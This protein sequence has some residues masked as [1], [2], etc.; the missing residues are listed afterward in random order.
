[1]TRRWGKS[2]LYTLIAVAGIAWLW[3]QMASVQS[4]IRLN[5]VRYH[6]SIMRT[7]AERERGLSGTDKLSEGNAMLFVFPQNDKWPMWMKDMN[8]PIDIVWVNEASQ[9]VYTVSSIQPSS[10]PD[11][12]PTPPAPARYVIELPAGSVEKTHIQVGNPVGLPSGV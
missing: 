1:M 8:Y 9:V 2:I 3:W 10:Y 4:M 7:E 11:Y 5:G 12:K 6:V